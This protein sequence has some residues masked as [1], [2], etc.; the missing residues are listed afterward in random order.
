MAALA[1]AA[2]TRA[3]CKARHSFITWN[4]MV[5]R[6][7]L[8]D[9]ASTGTL[10]EIIWAGSTGET[11]NQVLETLEEWNSYLE[12]EGI[13]V[14]GAVAMSLPW[15]DS[16]PGNLYQTFGRSASQSVLC[17]VRGLRF[18]LFGSP[19]K[20]GHDWSKRPGKPHWLPTSS[21]G[22]STICP[23]WGN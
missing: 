22:C 4:L 7:H 16:P 10:T 3:P 2:Q 6:I 23:L 15:A 18:P 11:W 21:S 8:G 14:R 9:Q 20:S 1:W 19:P 5:G 12:R 17:G 13:T